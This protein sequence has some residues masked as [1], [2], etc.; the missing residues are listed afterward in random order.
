MASRGSPIRAVPHLPEPPLVLL[1]REPGRFPLLAAGLAVPARLPQHEDKL[2]V[3]FDD[4]IG[5]VRLSQ[6]TRPVLD[7][8]ACVRYLVPQNGSKVVEAD[9]PGAHNNVRMQGHNR[10]PAVL[11]AREANVTDDAHE[12]AARD[13]RAEAM[14]PYLVELVMEGVIVLD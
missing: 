10:M 6:E 14:P 8:V 11:A 7:F 12:A 5:L 3:I 9:P 13:E 4:G 2:N 1:L